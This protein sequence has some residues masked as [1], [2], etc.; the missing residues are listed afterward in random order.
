MMEPLLDR[1][2]RY[3]KHDTQA[4]ASAG[5]VPSSPGQMELARLLAEELRGLGLSDVAVDRHAYV[6]ATLPARGAPHAPAIGLLAHLDTA[7]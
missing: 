3:V 2:L 4:D 7:C 1:F 5:V 6:T